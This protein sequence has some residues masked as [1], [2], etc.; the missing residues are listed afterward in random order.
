MKHQLMVAGVDCYCKGRNP[1]MQCPVCEWGACVCTNCGM[2]E[3]ELSDH[4]VCLGHR[5]GS[6]T[7]I[8]ESER[9]AK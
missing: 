3:C 9:I 7:E 6:C 2:A 5:K 1:E 8:P 4:P